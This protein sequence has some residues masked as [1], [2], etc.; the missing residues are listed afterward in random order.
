MPIWIKGNVKT[1]KKPIWLRGKVSA[2]KRNLFD[3]EVRLGPILS[4]LTLLLSQIGFFYRLQ[5]Y[6]LVK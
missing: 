1:Y 6:L 4:A 3:Y 5:P 2:D